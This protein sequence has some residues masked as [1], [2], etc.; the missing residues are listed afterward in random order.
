MRRASFFPLFVSALALGAT[1]CDAILGLG[2]YK[3]TNDPTAG[4]GAAGGGGSGPSSTSGSTTMSS[5]ASMT[6]SSSSTGG[7]CEPAMDYPCYDGP[8][9]TANVGEC[10][11]GTHTCNA[12]GETFTACTGQ[13]LP[14]DE[15]CRDDKHD[16]D[17]DHTECVLDAFRFGDAADQTIAGVARDS[18]GNIF[19][20]GTFK[21]TLAFDPTKPLVATS[22]AGQIYVAKFDPMGAPLW[23][24]TFAST[25]AV[26]VS[27]LT[28]D[29]NGAVIFT[30]TWESY[31]GTL[32]IGTM[33]LP[34]YDA[35]VEGFVA[36][37]D[38]SGNHVFSREI[39]Y[40]QVNHPTPPAVDLAGNVFVW[41]DARC[42]SG[43]GQSSFA[44]VKLSPTNTVLW[45]KHTYMNVFTL[46]TDN[47]ARV[48]RGVAADYQG[49]VY[50]VGGFKGSELLGGSTSVTSA[51][52][53]D[54]IIGKFNSAGTLL[55]KWR[56]GDA[57]DQ[58]AGP[59]AVDPANNAYVATAFRGTV[60]LPSGSSMTSMGGIDIGLFQ[61][62]G[63]GVFGWN[64]RF[65][66]QADQTPVSIATSNGQVVVASSTAGNVDYGGGVL[67]GLGG[68]DISVVK[69]DAATGLYFW[70]RLFG[71]STND[72]IGAIFL[73]PSGES[74]L[75]ATFMG[76]VDLGGGPVT[77]AGGTDL[78][79]ARLAP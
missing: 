25:S 69:V 26:T 5:A 11:D 46:S 1:G 30:G 50:V 60:T 58:I 62:S 77:S 14:A 41:A 17:C 42:V 55:N 48:A 23:S 8:A 31:N 15:T 12:D 71:N 36:K 76:S 2:D 43:C 21:G 74:M 34:T 78:L 4:T 73:A 13:V 3:E 7:G 32:T 37:L 27:G 44:L 47:T 68:V 79:F 45:F 38:A 52:G 22:T 49:N 56:F 70:S 39:E 9:M 6:T 19:I 28:A 18:N 59:I 75:G 64:K 29:M 72:S 66:D 61:L 54:G 65:G 10:S 67:P 40:D 33:P 35:A 53:L 63:A 51:G 24:K 16:E 20:A 57:A